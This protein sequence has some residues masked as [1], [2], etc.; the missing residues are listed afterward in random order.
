MVISLATTRVQAATHKLS[1]EA[2]TTFRLRPELP[3]DNLGGPQLGYYNVPLTAG[4]ARTVRLQIFNPTDQA[5]TVFG[6]VRDATTLD[7]GGVDY[8]G[9]QSIDRRLLANPGS[10]LVSLPAKTRLQPQQTKWL[11]IKIATPPHLFHGQKAVALN[12]SATQANTK[13]AVQN[14]YIYAI[15]LVLNG[16]SLKPQQYRPIQSPQIK[17]ELR[18]R[19]AAINV[20]VVN[21]NP[22]YLKET[23]I[24][25]K[26]QNSRWQLVQYTQQLAQRKI[27][28]SSRFN[29]ALLLGGKRLVPGVYK[30]TLT[31][32]S[33]QQTST[34]RQ[35]VQITKMQAHYINQHNAQYLKHRLLIWTS[36]VGLGVVIVFCGYHYH[37]RK[38]AKHV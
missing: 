34:I 13:T 16:R 1:P 4:Q 37:K 7:N 17:T 32:K 19:K 38:Q 28:P 35:N 9:T 30:M 10:Q 2:K 14:H 33:Q 8:L 25:I 27:A 12:L 21:P 15:G 6:Q 22:A 11:T 24:S 26:L 3:A 31:V 23:H 29:V 36:V 18:Q 5:L 20:A